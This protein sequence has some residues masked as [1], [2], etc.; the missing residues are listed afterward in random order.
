M[1]Y[2][3]I[4]VFLL[5]HTQYKMNEEALCIYRGRSTALGDLVF[6]GFLA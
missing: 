3:I 6:L 1:P 2:F 5:E 4:I